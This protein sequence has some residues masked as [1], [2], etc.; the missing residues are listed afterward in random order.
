M[1]ILGEMALQ[2][3]LM[4]CAVV[5]LVVNILL[6]AWRVLAWKG[7]HPVNENHCLVKWCR[8]DLYSRS[9]GNSQIGLRIVQVKPEHSSS[10]TD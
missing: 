7:S 2:R 3:I 6:T 4:V 8:Y 5:L 10:I 1:F 9:Q